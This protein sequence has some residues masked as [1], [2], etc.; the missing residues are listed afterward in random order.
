M[1]RKCLNSLLILGYLASQLAAIPHAHGEMTAA[2]QQ[3]HAATPHFHC[4]G[5]GHSHTHSHECQHDH[6]GPTKPGK[7][8]DQRPTSITV[9]TDSGFNHDADAV[10]L[11]SGTSVVV[12]SLP[13][14]L[15]LATSLDVASI[16]IVSLSEIPTDHSSGRTW[17]HTSDCLTD[18]S[19]LYLA[20]R[21]LR[22]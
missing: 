8:D 10:F 11:P 2:E 16:N 1:F 5:M 22:I 19:D 18:H 15:L 4:H 12:S 9:S 14:D 3:A 13:D 7:D 21:Q 6:Q 20:L 17:G